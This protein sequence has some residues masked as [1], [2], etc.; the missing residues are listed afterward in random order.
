MEKNTKFNIWYVL[1]AIWGVLILQSAQVSLGDVYQYLYTPPRYEDAAQWYAKASEAGSK[2]AKM[3]LARLYERGLG[4]QQDG[5]LAVNLWREATGAGEELVLAS[6]LEA[7]R[8]AADERIAQLTEQL[9]R[10]S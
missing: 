1:A 9:Q 2:K 7:A 10:R 5:L 6:E 3:Q 4:T 8:T